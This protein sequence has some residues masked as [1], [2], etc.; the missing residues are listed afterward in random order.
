MC[1]FVWLE[2]SDWLGAGILQAFDFASDNSDVD[3]TDP[4][5]VAKLAYK[6]VK[7][8]GPAAQA[9]KKKELEDEADGMCT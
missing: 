4:L 7:E 9:K 1:L 8:M 5:A 6:G 2:A 3:V